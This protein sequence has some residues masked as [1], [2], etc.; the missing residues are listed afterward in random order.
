M[1]YLCLRSKY[2]THFVILLITTVVIMKFNLFELK[3]KR[4]VLYKVIKCETW[5]QEKVIPLLTKQTSLQVQVAP[6]GSKL[7][8]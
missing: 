1:F 2:F 5:Q 8:K 3:R 4:F 7:V 6:L